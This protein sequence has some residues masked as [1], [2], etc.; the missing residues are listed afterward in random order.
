MIH[1]LPIEIISKIFAYVPI[2][3]IRMCASAYRI[4]VSA[5]GIIELGSYNIRMSG[6]GHKIGQCIQERYSA[7]LYMGQ[8]FPNSK[9]L[10]ERMTAYGAWVSGSRLLEFLVPGSIEPDSDWDFYIPTDIKKVVYFMEF[11]KTL[12][13]TWISTVE[14]YVSRIESGDRDII[15]PYTDLE[16][17]SKYTGSDIPEYIKEFI[18]VIYEGDHDTDNL[19]SSDDTTYELETSDDYGALIRVHTGTYGSINIDSIIRGKLS[20]H[21][22][23]TNIQLILTGKEE[24]SNMNAIRNFDLSIVQGAIT[25]F[26]VFH[27]YSSHVYNK[28]GSI[29]T[30]NEANEIQCDITKE[31][32][33]KY[34]KRGFKLQDGSVTISENHLSADRLIIRHMGDPDTDMIV[35]T[36]GIYH[37]E[38]PYYFAKQSIYNYTWTETSS[39]ISGNFIID[40]RIANVIK[41][42]TNYLRSQGIYDTNITESILYARS[43]FDYDSNSDCDSNCDCDPNIN[44]KYTYLSIDK[45]Y[46][47]KF[48][49]LANAI[50][51]V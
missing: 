13:V 42:V 32:I 20:Y 29:W 25:G 36:T 5:K 44:S 7:Q 16:Y 34:R 46:Y 38:D 49:P 2:K 6:I 41:N 4:N 31:R 10:M 12:G 28:S 24:Y 9:E 11:M 43:N 39:S 30:I 17:L 35:Y 19:Q 45:D 40:Q 48:R 3:D 23:E 15:M 22:I 8:S 27:M 47:R 14:Y 50:D 18:M 51:T 21:G 37:H 33:K 1:R 26:M